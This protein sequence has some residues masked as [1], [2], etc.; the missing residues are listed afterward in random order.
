MS[1][2]LQFGLTNN[3]Q[4]NITV[5]CEM[6]GTR[7]YEWNGCKTGEDNINFADFLGPFCFTQQ[8]EYAAYCKSAFTFTTGQGGR[9]DCLDNPPNSELKFV[10]S[11]DLTQYTQ[12]VCNPMLPFIDGTG[13]YNS[14]KSP[15]CPIGWEIVDAAS[16]SSSCWYRVGYCMLEF[17]FHKYYWVAN[18]SSQAIVTRC[19]DE[20]P[21][22]L[23][24]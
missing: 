2:L 16:I 14:V 1:G 6:D 17:Y 10:W 19:C 13:D 9:Q 8:T 24:L 3:A 11:D 20:I 23:T 18:T 4:F 12:P 15:R 22:S 5:K 7:P 21:A